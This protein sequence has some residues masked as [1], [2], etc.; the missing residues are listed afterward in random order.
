[1][2]KVSPSPAHLG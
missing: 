1:M 2:G